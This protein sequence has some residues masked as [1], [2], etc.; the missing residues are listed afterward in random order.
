MTVGNWTARDIE[1]ASTYGICLMCGTPREYVVREVLNKTGY[2]RKDGE[3][4]FITEARI[5]CPNDHPQ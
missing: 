4:E 5:V 2:A 3:P 1:N